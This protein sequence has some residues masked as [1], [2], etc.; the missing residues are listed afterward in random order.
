MWIALRRLAFFVGKA[1][2]TAQ[3]HTSGG[4]FQELRIAVRDCRVSK[5]HPL[6]S[7]QTT[8]AFI[9]SHLTAVSP[10]PRLRMRGDVPPR[11]TSSKRGAYISEGRIILLL[12]S[13]S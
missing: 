2:V 12:P 10:V 3:R 5:L 9:W 8:W 13:Y 1:V 11:R 6:S 7:K 4:I